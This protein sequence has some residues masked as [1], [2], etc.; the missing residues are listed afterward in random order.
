MLLWGPWPGLDMPWIAWGW[1]GTTSVADPQN[2]F[3]PQHAAL[4]L[5]LALF[6][7]SFGPLTAGRLL[8]LVATAALVIT[9]HPFTAFALLTALGARLVAGLVSGEL[10][11]RGAAALVLVP[12]LGL[13][14]AG[15][16]PYYPVWRLLGVL[17]DAGFR[18]PL[19]SVVDVDEEAATAPSPSPSS[20]TP[21]R[22]PSGPP[23]EAPRVDWIAA[24]LRPWHILGPAL[25]LGLAG[26]ALLARRGE[27][28]LLLWS[29]GALALGLCPWIPLRERLLL[30]AAVPLQLAASGLLAVLWK[31]HWG[32]AV[33]AA[34]LLAAGFVA[35][36][37]V[38]FV[39]D[40]P[41]LDFGFVAAAT[42]ADAVILAPDGINNV[43]AG[44]TGRKVVS[45]EGPDLFLILAGGA[46]RM[47][48]D[49]LFYRWSTS[50][51]RRSAILRRW[52]VDFV[53]ID[54]FV[55][56]P[57]NPPGTLVAERDG[58]ALYDVRSLRR[59]RKAP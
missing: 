22:T 12:A 57:G 11:P 31:R 26:A 29:L 58:L 33:A 25:V 6:L 8:R 32:R 21:S 19:P 55:G 37:R 47:L 23:R 17:P 28:L 39:R 49:T 4:T 48:D 50:P 56:F 44:Q 52:H 14:A 53:V 7:D 27:P 42:P 54:R 46:Q 16:W 36:E 13:I 1:P 45:P 59:P 2:F 5:V 41:L 43:L 3:Y 51:E 18:E 15:A 34:F 24:L 35:W 30:F 38:C 40:L 9:V 20:R 10:R